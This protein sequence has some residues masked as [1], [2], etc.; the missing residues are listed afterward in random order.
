M[1]PSY[2]IITII[3]LLAL[4]WYITGSLKEFYYKQIDDELSSKA[5][6]FQSQAV[7]LL[8]NK[9]FE[10]VDRLSKKMFKES[11]T[12]ITVIL[13]SGRV[14]ADSEAQVAEMQNH[15]DRPEF[16]EAITKGSGKSI[17]LSNTIGVNMMYLATVISD[18]NGP[19]AVIRASIP[20]TAIDKQLSDIYGKIAAGVIIAAAFAA[21]VSLITSRIISRPV[22]QMKEAAEKFSIGRF[23][24]R[25]PMFNSLE[26]N[27]LSQEL[28]NMAEQLQERIRTITKQHN[29]T[30]AILS[31]MVEGV[32]AVD[33][34]GHIVSIN[35][36]AGDFAGVEPEKVSG[37]N[38]EEVIRNP[39]ILDFLKETLGSEK[40]TESDISFLGGGKRHFRLHGA[41]LAD[42]A[43][44]ASGAVI[45]L[46]DVTRIARLENIRRDFVANVSHEL[47]TPITSIKGFVETLLDGALKNPE[48]TERF[49]KIIAKHADRLNAIVD[50]L[51]SLSRLEEDGDVRRINFEK[52]ALADILGDAAE[53][54][55]LKADGKNIALKVECDKEIKLECNPPLLEQAVMNLIDNAIKYSEP[56]SEVVITGREDEKEIAISV[57]D[58]G[59]GIPKEHLERIF[60]R[61]YVVDKSRSRKLGG[62]GLGLAIVKHI[63]QIHKG[64]VA[65]ESTLDK[66]STFTIHLPKDISI[67]RPI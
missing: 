25:V 28:N 19:V 35:K 27:E 6:M 29:E 11:S 31:S 20:V 34:A 39:D 47:K 60:E 33:S 37:L 2:L 3:A 23:D 44:V 14:A 66:G 10:E 17:R 42:S 50:D 61:F 22:V 12:R 9:E 53:L 18:S 1:Y 49:L 4:G 56:K 21:I 64:L 48:E 16:R 36:A 59:C 67:S 57:K 52:T 63:S 43:G 40:P 38:I 24:V 41:R 65:V 62:T 58:N 26:L 46:D 8:K 32:I 5:M 55:K 15:S 45:V 51:L 13:P 30:K 54:A 7:E